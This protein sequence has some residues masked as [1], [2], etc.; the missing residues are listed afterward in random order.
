[1]FIRIYRALPNVTPSLSKCQYYI[2]FVDDY[3]HKVWVYFLKTKDEAFSKFIE[4]LALVE[5]QSGKTLKAL[6]TDKGLEYCNKTFDDFCKSKEILRHK[7]CM[8]IPQQNGVAERLNRTILEKLR[9]LLIS[10]KLP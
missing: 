7:T 8:Y 2:S 1:M 6:R 5:N 3:S 4:W 10:L 9:S